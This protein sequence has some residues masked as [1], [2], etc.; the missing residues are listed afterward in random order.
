[1]MEASAIIQNAHGIHCRP[2]ALIIKE[3]A[4]YDG[5]IE[6]GAESG[7][8]NLKSVIGLIG[9]GL[10]QG[11]QITIHVSGPDE[12]MFCQ[13]LVELFERHFDFPQKV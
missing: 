11:T 6:V 1:M 5:E 7:K 13:R 2:S 10:E 4:Y 3:T 8:T 12:A 9:L